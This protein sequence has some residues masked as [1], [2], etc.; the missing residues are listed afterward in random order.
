MNNLFNSIKSV[1]SLSLNTNVEHDEA[2]LAQSCD[3]AELELRM[4]DIEQRRRGGPA[5]GP[6]GLFIR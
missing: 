6:Y 1:F 3:L 5:D 4:R 2:Y